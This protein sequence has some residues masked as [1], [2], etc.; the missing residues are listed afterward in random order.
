M[1]CSQCGSEYEI[2]STKVMWRDSDSIHCE[3]CGITL[4][5]WSGGRVYV[6][7]LIK[8]GK[9]PKKELTHC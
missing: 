2:T 9:W 6:A 5:E 1:T 3:V 8:R 4:K 7:T